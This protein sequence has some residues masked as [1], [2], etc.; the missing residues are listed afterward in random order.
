MP[1][2]PA[3]TWILSILILIRSRLAW[4]TGFVDQGF[5]SS[6]LLSAASGHGNQTSSRRSWRQVESRLVAPRCSRRRQSTPQTLLYQAS[7]ELPDSGP[8][9]TNPQASSWKTRASYAEPPASA[10]TSS[11]QELVIID[12]VSTARSQ[13]AACCDH[14]A[15]SCLVC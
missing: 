15:G 14:A 12:A 6:T 8:T 11:G 5:A 13:Q 1:A 10:S 7:S 2:S 9:C 4:C 3:V